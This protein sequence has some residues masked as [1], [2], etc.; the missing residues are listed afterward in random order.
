MVSLLRCDRN[1]HV[2]SSGLLTKRHEA[3]VQQMHISAYV[4]VTY[5]NLSSFSLFILLGIPLL[6]FAVCLFLLYSLMPVVIGM[7]SATALNLNLL[8][9][10]FYA[11]LAGLFI[12]YYSVSNVPDVP[13]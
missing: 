9:A 8:T 7:T 12:F 13:V 1:T 11:I 2:A 6:G 3:S 5:L 10:D 4:I